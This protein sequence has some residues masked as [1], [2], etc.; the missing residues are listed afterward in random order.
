[1]SNTRDSFRISLRLPEIEPSEKSNSFIPPDEDNE[2]D[3][4][5]S[6]LLDYQKQLHIEYE[7]ASQDCLSSLFYNKRDINL[8]KTRVVGDLLQCNDMDGLRKVAAE[9]AKNNVAMTSFKTFRLRDIV[10]SI[11]NEQPETENTLLLA[12]KL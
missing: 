1:M 7:D 9:A 2:L 8:V 11:L 6:K 5:K 12:K 10:S 4:I 3:M